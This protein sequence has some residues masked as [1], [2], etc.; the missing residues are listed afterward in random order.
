VV[1]QRGKRVLIPGLRRLKQVGEL[2]GLHCIP[3]GR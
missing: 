1:E 2:V 3:I